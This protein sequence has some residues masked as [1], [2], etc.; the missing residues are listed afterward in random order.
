MKRNEFIEYVIFTIAFV[1]SVVLLGV[2]A[3]LI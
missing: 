2:G 3:K 1:G